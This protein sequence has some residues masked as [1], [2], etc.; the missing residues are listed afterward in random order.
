MHADIFEGKWRQMRGEL[1]SWW[2][3]LS[4]NDLE[5]IAGKKDRLIGVLQEKYG[6]T[7]EAAQ[8]EID[9]RFKEYD[10]R[11]ASSGSGRREQ[12]MGSPSQH[13]GAK[14]DPREEAAATATEE[15]ASST[16]SKASQPISAVGEKIGA[17]ADVIRDKAPH[18]GA[19][20]TAATTMADKLGAAGS[21]LQQKNLDH[22][23]SDLS[24]VIR[25]YPVPS[26][27]IGLGI[28]YLLARS[29]R[30]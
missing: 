19:V 10:E 23:M 13:Y 16:M 4:D 14:L 8:Q 9:R 28:G 11:T 29:T 1:R 2:G 17:L 20:A 25:R 3:R 22:M 18:E 30:R 7:H 5:K 12:T 6:Y 26:L 27:L 15:T 24:S 21:Y